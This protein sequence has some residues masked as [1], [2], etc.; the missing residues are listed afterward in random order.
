MGSLWHGAS[1]RRPE[2]LSAI[3]KRLDGAGLLAR[4]R[5]LRGRPATDAE[6]TAVHSAALVA[7]V[8][9][10]SA[11]AAQG[12]SVAAA[13]A[14]TSMSRP[15]GEATDL[16]EAGGDEEGA[17]GVGGAAAERARRPAYSIQPPGWGGAAA[18]GS[19]EVAGGSGRGGGEAAEAG[20][21]GGAM[22]ALGRGQV[23]GGPWQ[24]QQ[25]HPQAPGWDG[26]AGGGEAQAEVAAAAARPGAEE[27]DA[28]AA[29][30]EAAGSGREEDGE[31]EAAAEAAGGALEVEGAEEGEGEGEEEEEE[32][33]EEALRL[34]REAEREEDE[35]WLEGLLEPFEVR[36]LGGACVCVASLLDSVQVKHAAL[37]IR[38]AP[39]R[40]VARSARRLAEPYLPWHER[41]WQR[42][43]PC[44]AHAQVSADTPCERPPLHSV[45]WPRRASPAQV[46][47]DTLVSAATH[48]AARLAAGSAALAARGVARGQFASGV[49]LVRPPGECL[50]AQA[51]GLQAQPP[52]AR[53]AP[54]RD[55]ARVRC[56]RAGCAGSQAGRSTA[57]QGCYFNSVAVAVAAAQQEGCERVLVLDWDVHHG[58]GTQVSTGWCSCVG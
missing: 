48:R 58:A 50:V 46:S 49:A 33:D 39:A 35:D 45:P 11:R 55:A 18:G 19:A 30:G 42:C 52:S 25:Q 8:E 15:D 2:R 41:V 37:S 12:P 27:V 29:S 5:L 14:P 38:P 16:L 32:D 20:Q 31:E 7:A 26:S 53:A 54:Q 6:L 22:G 3:L 34:L 9:E 17:A 40:G 56:A 21:G 13:A 28:R 51:Q 24:Q 43:R 1:A 47:A 44:P 4:C 23:D 57:Q 10:A 36:C